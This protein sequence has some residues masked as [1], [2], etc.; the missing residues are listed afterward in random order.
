MKNSFWQNLLGSFDNKKGAGFSARKLT[1]FGGFMCL[2]YLH[3]I[4]EP[5]DMTAVYFAVIDAL[6]I[7]LCLGLVTFEQILKLKEDN[8]QEILKNEP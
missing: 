2:V 7:L 4:A 6:F 3:K 5:K 1:A 8:R